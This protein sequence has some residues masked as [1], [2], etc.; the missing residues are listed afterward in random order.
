ML[1]YMIYSLSPRFALCFIGF[2]FSRTFELLSICFQLCTLLT[3]FF[4]P[5]VI[6]VYHISDCLSIV[7][8]YKL[9]IQFLWY[10]LNLHRLAVCVVFVSVIILY[11]IFRTMSMNILWMFCIC[12]VNKYYLLIIYCPYIYYNTLY[13][14]K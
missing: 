13:I 4:R 12:F 3:L 14:Q 6:I 2:D 5:S 1:Y 9:Y 7:K 8:L 11:H 10:L